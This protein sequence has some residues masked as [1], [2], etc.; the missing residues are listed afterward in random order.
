MVLPFEKQSQTFISPLI[1]LKAVHWH[2]VCQSS[3]L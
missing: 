3:S 1:P 2:A